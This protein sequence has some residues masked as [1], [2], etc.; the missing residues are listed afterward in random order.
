MTLS[1]NFSLGKILKKKERER[2][3]TYFESVFT[4]WCYSCTYADDLNYLKQLKCFLNFSDHIF[5][6]KSPEC[7]C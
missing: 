6:V 5:S 4:V 2:R 1:A 7:T 3:K